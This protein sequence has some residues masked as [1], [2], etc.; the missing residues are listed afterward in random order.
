MALF[1]LVGLAKMST[2]HIGWN[3]SFLPFLSLPSEDFSA[4]LALGGW[5]GSCMCGFL[6][7]VMVVCGMLPP[8]EPLLCPLHSAQPQCV[9]ATQAQ[10]IAVSDCGLLMGDV[11]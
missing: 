10:L 8:H 6:C 2:D 1:F 3:V 5:G 4:E 7:L 11:P 9:P